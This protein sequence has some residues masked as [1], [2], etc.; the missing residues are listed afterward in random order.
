[1]PSLIAEQPRLADPRD[2]GP[3]ASRARAPAIAVARGRSRCAASALRRLRARIRQRRRDVGADVGQAVGAPAPAHVHRR[4]ADAAP[5]RERDDPLLSHA[6]RTVPSQP[7]TSSATCR[8]AALLFATWRLGT[9][10]VGPVTGVLAVALVATRETVVFYGPLAYLDFPYAALVVWAATLEARS[11][12]RGTPVL[13]LLTV[14]GLLRPE[15]WLFAGL[16]WLWLAP[17]LSR[18]LALRALA[19]IAAAPCLWGLFDLVTAGDP[20]FSF[21]AHDQ[22]GAEDRTH[23]LHDLI[24]DGAADPRPTGRAPAVVAMAALGFVLTLAVRQA[25]P[26]ARRGDRSDGAGLQRA[27][28]GWHRR[29]PALPAADRRPH[30]RG[31][32]G[33]PRRAG[34]ASTG[35]AR[36]G[37]AG[38]SRRS[39][40]SPWSSRRLARPTVCATHAATWSPT[41]RHGSRLH[42]T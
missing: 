34:R 17:S 20:V 40:W 36:D 22:A 2:A 7:G 30:V 12:R 42:G 4:H 3:D 33:L 24:V 10:L 18:P 1:M 41:A 37:V 31:G 38:G 6:R 35:R 13:V 23:G 27:G 21:T 8:S 39:R 28:G 29:E 15:A 5:A 25:R 16:Y 19:L 9:T 14:A 26:L 11:P 32:S